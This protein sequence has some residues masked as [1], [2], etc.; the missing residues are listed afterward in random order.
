[1]HQVLF[2]VKAPGLESGVVA[3]MAPRDIFLAACLLG[4]LF[5]SEWP[6]PGRRSSQPPPSHR[7][8]RTKLAKVRAGCLLV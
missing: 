2:G 5:P 7:A 3:A 8:F 1:M 4:D 6:P